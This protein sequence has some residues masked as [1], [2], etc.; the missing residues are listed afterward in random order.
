MQISDPDASNTS[1]C[2]LTFRNSVSKNFICVT[3][4]TES[5]PFTWEFTIANTYFHGKQIKIENNVVIS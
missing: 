3:W 1:L 5:E 4:F 2:T